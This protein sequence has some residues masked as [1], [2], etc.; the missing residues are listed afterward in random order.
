MEQRI[1]KIIISDRSRQMLAEHLA[2]LA[3]VSLPSARGLQSDFLAA[4]RSLATMP[5]R[6]PVLYAHHIPRGK[7]HKMTVE[8]RYLVLFQIREDVVYVDFII[9]GRQDYQWLIK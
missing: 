2:F 5:E 4:I 3:Q 7:Y 9:D 8:K 1:Y 6:F